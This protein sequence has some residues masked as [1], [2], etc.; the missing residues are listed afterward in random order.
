MKNK[1][2][3]TIK[4]F[5]TVLL[6]LLSSALMSFSALSQA[7]SVKD[8]QGIFELEAIPQRIVVL[9]FSF[10]DALAAVDVS[11]VGV[12]DDNDATRVIPAVRDKIEPWQSVGMR[13]QP[14]LEAIAVLKPDLIIADAE[15]HRAIYQDLQRIAPTLLLK[16]RGETYQEN[17][18][19]AQKIGVAIGKQEQMTQRIEQHKQTMAEFKQH[20]SI[21]ETIQ[22]GVVSD[23]GMWLHSRVS[24]AGGVLSTLGI[25]SPLAPSERNA[26]IPTS[27]ELLLKTN[28]D[29]LLVGLYS[30]PNIVDEWRKNPLFKLLTAAKKQQLVEASPELWSLNRGML[31]AEEIARNLE[32]LLGRS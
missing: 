12:A 22:F 30:Q 6:M 26:Y 23:K 25:Q 19:S 17:L 13:S 2:Q 21:Q 20:F 8:E 5:S 32:A 15:R 14:S 18:E 9:E 24:Y 10:V 28:P 4:H 27:F 1:K 3:F 11:P 7:R 31:A 29:W 16:S